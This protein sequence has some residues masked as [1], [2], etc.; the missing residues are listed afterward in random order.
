MIEVREGSVDRAESQGII[1]QKGC[2]KY[3]FTK[4]IA[5]L[6]FMVFYSGFLYVH[7]NKHTFSGFHFSHIYIIISFHLFSYSGM[8]IQMIKNIV[9]TS[10][11][12]I[13]N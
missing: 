8:R 3:C 2:A 6:G 13:F 11:G 1:V 12:N 10:F 5:T 4:S 9:T 7:A